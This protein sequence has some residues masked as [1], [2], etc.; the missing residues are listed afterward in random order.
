MLHCLRALR[1]LECSIFKFLLFTAA[2]EY[3]LH[4]PSQDVSI[5]EF[6]AASGVGVV[7]SSEEIEDAVST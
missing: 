7:V 6:D 4:H 1:I 2:L 3:L 5:P